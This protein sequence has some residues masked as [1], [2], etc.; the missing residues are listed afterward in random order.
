MRILL[1]TLAALL[2]L[3]V[4]TLPQDCAPPPIVFNAKTENIFTPE[5][6][7]YL[8]DAM[9]EQLGNDYR[10]IDDPALNSY[11][12][13]IGDRIA[14]HLPPSGIKF[15]LVVV[16]TPDTNAYAMAGGRIMIP[17]KMV[18]FVRNEDELAWVIG[19]ELGHAVVRH[20]AIDLS[21]SFKE[22]LNI[23]SFGDRKDVVEKYNRLLE[24]Y[25]TKRSSRRDGH[26]N[27]QQ[28]E[29]DRIGV[30][31]IH[32]A[33]YDLSTMTGF[34]KRLTDAKKVG[35][36]AS[37]FVERQPVDKRLSEMVDAMKG[38]PAKCR[39]KTPVSASTDFAKWKAFVISHT[40]QTARESLNGLIFRRTLVPLRP[41]LDHLR[42]SPDGRYILAQD[43][44]MITVL[45]REPLAVLFRF[46]VEDAYPANFSSDSRTVIVFNE[47]LRVQKWSVAEQKLISIHEVAVPP[48]YWQTRISPDGNSVACYRYNGDLA[49]YDVATNEEIFKEKD[50][51]LPSRF[52]WYW[53][54]WWKLRTDE[55]EYWAL[56][57]EFSPDGRYFVAGRRRREY[58]NRL[59][60]ERE[61]YIGVDLSTRKK[62]SIGENIRKVVYETMAF[63]SPDK[64][65]GQYG[66]DTKKSGVFSFPDGDRIAQFELAGASFQPTQAGNY[67]TVRPVKGAAVGLFDI[68]NKKFLLGNGKPALDGYGKV[69]VAE[70]RD[71]EIGLFN[72]DT[73]ENIASVALPASPFG[74]LRATAIS[75]NG[76]WLVASDRSR[77]AAWDLRT[78]DRKLHVRSFR[79]A[80]V[81][82]D[83]KAYVDF[84]KQG[85][86]ERSV[87]VMDLNT[88][89]A[90]SLGD[91][92]TDATVRQYGRYLLLQKALKDTK[93]LSEKEKADEEKEANPFAEEFR[94]RPLPDKGV[95]ME[96]HDVLTGGLLW[97]REFVNERPY[98]ILSAHHDT[99]LLGWALRS[100]EA[101]R[102]VRSDPALKAKRDR[103]GDKDGDAVLEIVDPKTGTSKGHFFIET[104]E[105][106]FT[107][108]YLRLADDYLAVSDDQNRILVYSVATGEIVSRFFGSYPALSPR[109]GT[110]AVENSPGRVSIYEIATGREVGSL[111][112]KHP[113]S[114]MLYTHGG[115]RLFVLTRDQSVF[116]FDSSKIQTNQ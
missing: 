81:A 79:G 47:N 113:I 104:G 13:G 73:K 88:G 24:A 2:V 10:V 16:D 43:S 109:A 25:R 100:D 61:V 42:F 64:V 76:N 77:G 116:V 83:A 85:P 52:E 66:N 105:G 67:V 91:L 15:T 34:W 50:F 68:D 114:L 20:H 62:V 82:P 70:R 55:N 106:S 41:D 11:L 6:E 74:I 26:E 44:S 51:Y 28:L 29:A 71:G 59:M 80:Y 108:E 19:H 1:S 17:R 103:M 36:F 87:G 7:M 72:I 8:G 22:L 31:A 46:E 33:G 5:Q 30:F 9:M 78:G 35:F 75:S 95:L 53:W 56:G 12:Q 111:A 107:P 54:Q 45:T 37:L 38:I 39:D 99:M 101:N 115:L 102:I 90:S 40:G 57:M 97:K 69:F 92:A 112:F 27:D 58:F 63:V 84:P 96:M 93:P 65:I 49:I 98:I 3:S 48:G 94:E 86:V 14:K 23:T 32:A 110:I 18:S 89:T 4:S 60:S 21:R